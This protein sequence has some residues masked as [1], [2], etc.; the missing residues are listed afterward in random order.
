MIPRWLHAGNEAL[1]FLVELVA[2]AA[3]AWWGSETGHGAAAHL[4]LGIGAPLVAVV[5]WGLFAAPRATVK[6]PLP[7]VLAVKAVVFG[8]AALALWGVGHGG[9]A[10]AFA[11]VALGNTALA[12]ADRQALMNASQ[13]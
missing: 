12:T 13:P 9:L 3:L 10:I 6:L 1:A 8:G 7:G 4:I 2:L 5:L 11:L